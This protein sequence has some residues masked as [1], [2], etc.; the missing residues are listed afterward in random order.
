M[1]QDFQSLLRVSGDGSENRYD[2]K[3]HSCKIVRLHNDAPAN[4]HNNTTEHLHNNTNLRLGTSAIV[5]LC[6][7]YVV[8]LCSCVAG[9]LHKYITMWLQSCKDK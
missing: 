9:L 3:S 5:R 6:G 7:R 2:K 1:R 4:M 8:W